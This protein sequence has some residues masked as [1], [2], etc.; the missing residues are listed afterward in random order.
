[1]SETK[2]LQV[3]YDEKLVGTLAMASGHKVAFQYSCLLY[4]SAQIGAI[5]TGVQCV[6][7]CMGTEVTDKV[8]ELAKEKNCRIITTPYDTF[9]A[10]RLICQAMPVSRCV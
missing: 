1:M 9:T 5:Q 4:T 7:V 8:L 3:M 10:S 6:V 2:T